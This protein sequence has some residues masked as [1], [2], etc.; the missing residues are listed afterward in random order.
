[1]LD[2]LNPNPGDVSAPFLGF[3]DAFQWWLVPFLRVFRH[4]RRRWLPPHRVRFLGVWLE[5]RGNCPP[6]VW[7]RT[8]L[9]RVCLGWV[10]EIRVSGLIL[11]Q[12]KFSPM[13]RTWNGTDVICHIWARHQARGAALGQGLFLT[14]MSTSCSRANLGAV[15]KVRLPHP[16]PERSPISFPNQRHAKVSL[17]TDIKTVLV[18]P[19]RKE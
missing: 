9:S 3:V 14:S 15:S 17:V 18:P 7:Q 16:E 10:K 5:S 1:M 2:N 4:I 13:I 12:D 11:I 8:L 19:E 6:Q